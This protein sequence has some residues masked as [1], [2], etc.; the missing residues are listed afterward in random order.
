VV[1]ELVQDE[2]NASRMQTEL[3]LILDGVKREEMLEAY[4]VLKT[5]LGGAGASLNAAKIVLETA[6]S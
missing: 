1:S 5:K 4:Q 2:C 3:K 6:N